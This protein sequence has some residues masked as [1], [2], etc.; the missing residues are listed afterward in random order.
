[1]EQ[2][3]NS[4][5]L[6]VVITCLAV[7]LSVIVF[8]IT[9]VRTGSIK[10]SIERLKELDEEMKFKTYNDL[11]KKSYAQSFSQFKDNYVL[12]PETKMLEKLDTQTNLQDEINKYIDTRLEVVLS[13]FLNTP[14]TPEEQAQSAYAES[15]VDLATLGEALDLAEEYRVQFGLPDTATPA[16]IFSKVQQY[17][18]DMK[19][20]LDKLTSLGLKSLDP[21]KSE[22]N[23]KEED[24]K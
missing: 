19:A 21:I 18:A 9:Y 11:H 20:K 22:K 6:Q 10:K 24:K 12:N 14:E 23:E 1:M 3:I 17:S 13:K 7:V 5:L 4:P 8:I 15:Q 2:F 16:E